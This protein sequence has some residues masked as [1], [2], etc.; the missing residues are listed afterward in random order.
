MA[1][2]SS[3]DLSTPLNR[4]NALP[5][6]VNW[7]S[8]VWSPTT[9]YYRNDIVIS[10]ITGGSYI[11]IT[12][13]TTIRG[14]GDPSTNP[15][16]WYVFGQGTAGVQEIRGSEYITVGP[17]STPEITNNGV[18]EVAIGQNINNLGT[19]TDPILE[20]LGITSVL[21]TPGISVT[22]NTVANT[23]VVYVNEGPGII[24][25]GD[26]DIILSHSGV[27]SLTQA[28]TPGL[29]VGPGSTP[30]I[31]NTGLLSVTVS[32]GVTN[33]GTPQEPDLTNGGVIDISGNNSI[34]ITE[35]PNVKLSTTHPSISLIGTLV[36]AV[37]TPSVVSA[38]GSLFGRIPVTQIPGS[39]WATSIATQQPYSTGTFTIH[40]TLGTFIQ[41]SSPGFSAFGSTFVTI[42]DSI[43]NK[44]YTNPGAVFDYNELYSNS[45]QFS[46][47]IVQT[48]VPILR[49][50][51]DLAS[52]WASGFREMTHIQLT[53]QSGQLGSSNSL[54]LT[55]Q[56]MNIFAVYNSGVVVY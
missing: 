53:Q 27:A 49:I 46:L 12:P 24:V 28:P 15:S 34:L 3:L 50:I 43:N 21:P 42:Y 18:C 52:L 1:A 30:V 56:N 20:D 6:A 25:T 13:S 35:F 4:L 41:A 10:P 14:G 7:R 8:E 32:T 2:Q 33:S 37:M 38:P 40:L 22:G 17:T 5:T 29:T 51:I 11:N 31:S 16:A 48:R 54:S 55:A 39:L 44:V 36:N 23:G 26:S 9:V 45:R 19:Q 47:A